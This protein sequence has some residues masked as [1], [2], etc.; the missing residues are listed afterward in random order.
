[1]K[2]NIILI[3]LIILIFVSCDKTTEQK[4]GSLDGY[5]YSSLGEPISGAS[6]SCSGENTTSN[7]NGHY[8]LNNLTYG[9]HILSVQKENYYLY[10]RNVDINSEIENIN[11]EIEP[12]ITHLHGF[13]KDYDTNIGIDSAIIVLGENETFSNS[14]GSYNLIIFQGYYNVEISHEEYHPYSGDIELN[15]NSF[16]LNYLYN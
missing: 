3:T 10:E 7:N 6:L 1:M 15:T 9:N 14:D 12:I 16:E 5:V 13:I 2:T 4:M 8:R 11:I